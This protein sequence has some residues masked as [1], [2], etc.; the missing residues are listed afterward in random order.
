M[1][2]AGSSLG[3]KRPGHDVKLSGPVVVASQNPDKIAEI[4]TVLSDL[5]VVID[6]GHRWPDVEETEDTLAG[7][8]LL[9]ARAVA[10]ITGRVAIGDD[11]GLEVDALGGAPGVHTARYAGPDASYE[12]NVAKLLAEMEGNRN[13]TAR[14]RTAVALVTPQGEEVVVEGVLEGRITTVR[15]GDSGFGYDPVFEVDGR[16]LSEM[17]VTEKHKI[18][19]RARALRALHDA[20]A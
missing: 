2:S 13:R 12:E 11:T 6:R 1:G 15:R 16:T 10:S 4:E 5:G 17:G 3:S 8:A 19:H 9:K 20:L 18:S 7:N 14:F